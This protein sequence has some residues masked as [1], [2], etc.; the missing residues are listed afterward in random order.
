MVH[1]GHCG[2]PRQTCW[3]EVGTGLLLVWVQV[4]RGCEAA[5]AE[6][7][8][9]EEQEQR[10]SAGGAV[11][12]ELAVSHVSDKAVTTA[13]P[14]AAHRRLGWCRNDAEGAAASA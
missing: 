3:C 6:L 13:A 9:Q 11:G 4:R 14:C 8:Q 7:R 2:D 10:L 5:A 1:A 12:A